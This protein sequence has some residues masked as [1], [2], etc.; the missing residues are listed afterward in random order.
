MATADKLVNLADLKAA[1]DT[2]VRYDKAQTLTNTQ[3]QTACSN[4]GAVGVDENSPDWLCKQIFGDDSDWAVDRNSGGTLAKKGRLFE[5]GANGSSGSTWSW[6]NLTGTVHRVFGGDADAA[7]E[8]EQV[9][10][11]YV[12]ITPVI[13]SVAASDVNEHSKAL[14]LNLYLNAQSVVSSTNVRVYIQLRKYDTETDAYVYSSLI[15]GRSF[16]VSPTSGA[17]ASFVWLSMS[18]RG[19]QTSLTSMMADYEEIAIYLVTRSR[20][21]GGTLIIEPVLYNLPN[22]LVV[23]TSDRD[24]IISAVSGGRYTC[25]ASYVTSLSFT[26]STDGICF[27]RFTSGSTPTV[28]TLP[29]TVKMPDWWTGVEANRTYEISI[30]DGVYGVVTSWA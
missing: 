5:I 6:T 30:A 28:L 22:P 11:D 17:Q 27:V 12:S 26:P 3:K 19:N 1:Y 4:I 7:A 15:S 18:V 20:T 9:S 25:S 29:N 2:T 24:P 8:R 13:T 16:A 14:A 21:I 23:S 10:A